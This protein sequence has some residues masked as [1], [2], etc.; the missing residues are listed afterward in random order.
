MVSTRIKPQ[1]GR[2]RERGAFGWNPGE[3][4]VDALDNR[5]RRS[6]KQ[7]FYTSDAGMR[8]SSALMDEEQG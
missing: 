5:S 6:Y 4:D 2:Q 1:G 8:K 3:K 7:T